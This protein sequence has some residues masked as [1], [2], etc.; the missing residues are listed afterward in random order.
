MKR[1][2]L[3]LGGTGFIG[4]RLAQRIIALAGPEDEVV[5]TDNLSRGCRDQEVENMLRS[6]A[7]VRLLEIDLTEPTAFDRIEG[8]FDHVYLLAS[9]VGVKRVESLPEQVLRINTLIILGALEWMARSGSGRIFFSSTSENYAGAYENGVL[10]VPTPE[11]VPLVI[12][13]IRNP[14]FSYAVTKIWGEAA[15]IFYGARHGFTSVIGRYHN[16]YGPRM[17]YDHVI[18]QLSVRIIQGEDPLGVMNPEHT[19]AFC[20]VDDAVEATRLLMDAPIKNGTIV[21]IGNNNE[22]LAIGEL[23]NRLLRLAGRRPEFVSRQAPRGSVARRVPALDLL[24]QLTAFC[25]AV[26]LDKGLAETFAW[27]RLHSAE[28][29]KNGKR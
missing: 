15:A 18:P 24:R 13:D 1:R 14:R 23:A 4:L 6:S 9:M 26:P 29:P 8:V 5:L 7:N 2:S 12:S 22:E 16:I 10:P 20:H 27:Y 17:G 25:P 3:I 21:N 28:N 19:R 11:S